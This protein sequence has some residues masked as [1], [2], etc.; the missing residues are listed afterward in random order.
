[1]SDV[2]AKITEEARQ[3]ATKDGNR[4]IG[5]LTDA[6]WRE[7]TCHVWLNAFTLVNPTEETLMGIGREVVSMLRGSDLVDDLTGSPIHKHV[8]IRFNQS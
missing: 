1:M 7:E 6:E 5:D 2:L 8:I 3:R 4:L